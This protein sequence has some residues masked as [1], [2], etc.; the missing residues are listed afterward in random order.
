MK[1][2]SINMVG[3]WNY[4]SDSSVYEN[5]CSICKKLLTCVAHDDVVI[6]GK[7]NHLFHENCFRKVNIISSGITLCPI[8]GNEFVRDTAFYGYNYNDKL[9]KVKI[10]L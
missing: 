5:K 7:C 6:K 9:K 8:D 10:N 2:K 1:I 3:E 4:I